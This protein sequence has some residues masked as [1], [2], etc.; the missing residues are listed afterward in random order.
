MSGQFLEYEALIEKVSAFEDRV[1]AA[2][3]QYLR[4]ACGCDR[5][6]RTERSAF[7]VEVATIR[8]WL[9]ENPAAR[10]AA[11]QAAKLASPDRCAFLDENGA[12]TIYPVRPLICRTHGPALVVDGAVEWCELCFEKMTPEAVLEAVP[13]TAMLDLARLNQ[14]LVLVN[15]RYLA[16]VGG[17]ERL[18]LATALR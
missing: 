4:C 15:A 13:A 16:Q 2:Q 5:C 1:E 17:A 14:L 6:C 11:L 18:P 8:A 10:E 3:A 12:C 7:A 9:A